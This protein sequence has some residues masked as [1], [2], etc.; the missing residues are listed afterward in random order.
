[1]TIYSARSPVALHRASATAL[2]LLVSGCATATSVNRA[3][4]LLTAKPAPRDGCSIQWAPRT[5]PSVAELTDSAALHAA[6]VGFGARHHLSDPSMHMLFSVGT[7]ANGTVERFKVVEWWMPEGTVGELQEIVR[8]HL[9]T[10]PSGGW[11]VRLLVNAGAH[12]RF[13][14]GRSER[15][16]PQSRT[17]FEV[18]TP[19]VVGPLR[20]NPVRLNIHVDA[21]GAMLGTQLVQGSGYD[22][23]DRWVMASIGQHKFSPGMVDG[24]PVAMS[25]EQTVRVKSR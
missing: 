23:I 25:Y 6:V 21:T 11:S 2:L 8:K 14:V 5:L 18:L 19:A 3:E 22:E 12:P 17:R 24:V 7:H 9:R 4:T 16:L 20:P 10:Q 1:M 15:C 13:R